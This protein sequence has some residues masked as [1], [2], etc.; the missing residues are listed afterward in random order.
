MMCRVSNGEE[1]GSLEVKKNKDRSVI[2]QRSSEIQNFENQRKTT[3][4][5]VCNK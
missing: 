3:V 5:S 4:G 2:S 1:V